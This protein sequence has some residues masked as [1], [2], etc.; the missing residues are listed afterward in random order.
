MRYLVLAAD[1]DG[2]LAQDG[3]VTDETLAALNKLRDTGRKL[4][5]VTGRE[6]DELLH[7]FPGVQFFDRVVAENGALIYEP[8]TRAIRILA[9]APPAEFVETLQ[10]RK[11]SPMSFGRVIIATWKPHEIVVLETIRDM[12]LDLQVIF[13]KDAVMILPAIVNKATG[14]AAALKEMDLPAHAVV[15]VG[16][17]ENDLAF[18]AMTGCAVA[19]QNALPT[20]KERADF[21]TPADHGR[22]VEQLIDHILAD[23]LPVRSGRS[24]QTE[25]VPHQ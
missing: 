1:Y 12:G 8:A 10:R 2:T 5:L 24:L 17:A 18:L 4:F 21:V 3:R 11:V 7:V 9:K 13:N 6:L 16:D 22:G 15:G 14:L 20:V 23:D 25:S 19:V